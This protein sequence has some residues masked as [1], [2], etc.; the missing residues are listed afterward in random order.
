MDQKD[1]I[2]LLARPVVGLD[3]ARQLYEGSA[4][5]YA[6]MDDDENVLYVGQSGNFGQ[7]LARHVKDKKKKD[8]TRCC[9]ADV[10]DAGMRLI[11]E[12]IWIAL[13]RPPLNTAVMLRVHS[14]QLTE[15]RY[16]R[17]RKK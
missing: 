12:T 6:L 15:I 11:Q 10:P 9:L 13:L 3:T 8:V 4:G 17:K 14:G 16:R 2:N 5:V 7:R 1:I